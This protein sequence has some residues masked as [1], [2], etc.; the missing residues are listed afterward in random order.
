MCTYDS[1]FTPGSAHY[2]KITLQLPAALST[3]QYNRL[4]QTAIK[5]YRIIGCRDYARVDIRLRNDRFYVL[6]INPNAD[7]SS[8]TSLVS[9]AETAGYC[10]GALSS[11]LVNF[12]AER[13]PRFA[14]NLGKNTVS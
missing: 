3:S 8:D 4:E 2:E 14:S 1:K 11:L 12:A 6:D 5:A 7:I 13:H 10:Y 9:A